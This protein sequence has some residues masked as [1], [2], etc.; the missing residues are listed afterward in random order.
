MLKDVVAGVVVSLKAVAVAA[1]A[2]VDSIKASSAVV[3]VAI[4]VVIV[5]GRLNDVDFNIFI[6]IY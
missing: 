5:V 4:A 2:A 3:V 6:G 1:T